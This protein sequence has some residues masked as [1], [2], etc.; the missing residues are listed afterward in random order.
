MLF[1]RPSRHGI[2]VTMC[3]G[4][5]ASEAQLRHDDRSK[6]PFPSFNCGTMIAPNPH[7]P[8]SSVALSVHARVHTVPLDDYDIIPVSPGIPFC[9][10]VIYRRKLVSEVERHPSTNFEEVPAREGSPT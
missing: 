4:F 1:G 5:D 6:P 3:A 9:A 2:T 10:A 7:S 8:P